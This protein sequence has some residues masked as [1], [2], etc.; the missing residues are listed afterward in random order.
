MTTK[1]REATRE[2]LVEA[3]RELLAEI[4]IQGATVE[5]ICERAGFTRGAFYSNY[6]TKDELILEIFD[7]E[8]VQMIA[9]MQSAVDSEMG[10]EGEVDG[11]PAALRAVDRFLAAYPRDRKSFLVHLEFVTHGVRERA[12]AEVYRQVWVETRDD[13]QKVL[14]RG[15]ELLGG[16][17]LVTA[18]QAVTLLIGAYEMAMRDALL[19]SDADEA[20][21]TQLEDLIPAL[22]TALVAQD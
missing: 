6:D 22:F 2:R 7:R 17:L 18:E 8:K 13:I 16:R 21:L 5:S 3:A 14:E 11:V 10:G 15:V 12:V 9:L 19:E 20:D 4:G 1:R